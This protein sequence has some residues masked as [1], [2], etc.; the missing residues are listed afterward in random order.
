M[1]RILQLQILGMLGVAGGALTSHLLLSGHMPAWR[2]SLA[3]GVA[4]AFLAWWALSV[5]WVRLEPGFKDDT[6]GGW[7]SHMI[8]LFWIGNLVT[9]ASFWLFMPYA[10]EAQVMLSMMICMG[11]VTIEAMTT[12]SSGVL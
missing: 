4:A 11:P 12:A 5:L 8:L 2:V 1:S 10:P 7:Q 9:L 6:A 3:D